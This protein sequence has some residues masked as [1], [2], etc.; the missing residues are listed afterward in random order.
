VL[1]SKKY[2]LRSADLALCLIGALSLSACGGSTAPPTFWTVEQAES[3]KVIRGTPLAITKCG[4]LGESRESAFR[5]FRCTGRIVAE[6]VPQLPVRVRYVLN[7]RGAYEGGGSA[8][9]A[10]SVR[11]DSFGV[12]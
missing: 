3:I 5:R 1:L 2:G 4:G 7:P 6:A 11:F 10:T 9:L 8:Y 12:P